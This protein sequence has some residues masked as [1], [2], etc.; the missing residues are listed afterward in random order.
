V[1]INIHSRGLDMDRLIARCRALGVTNVGY[2]CAGMPGYA[3]QG[4]PDPD[5]LRRNL[6]QLRQAGIA[7]PVAVD[8]FGNDPAVVLEPAGHRA[9]IDAACRTLSVLGEAGIPAV[10]HYIDL[11]QSQEPADDDAYW[12]G[13]ITVFGELVEAAERADVRLANHA[14]WRCIPDALRPQALADG[15]TMATY[16]QYRPEGW[17]GPYLLTSGEHIVRLL[18]AVPSSHNGACFCT[19]MYIM[20]GDLPELADALAGKIHYAQMRDLRGRWPASE[21]VFPGTGELDFAAILTDLRRVGYDGVFGPEH[22]GGPR[23]PGEDVEAA[24][25]RYFQ[26][27]LA[28]MP[29]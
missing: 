28:S 1:E 3:E 24:A 15:V 13:L 12:R 17:R 6:D 10:L 26:D 18:E 22:L 11:A 14:I 29:R 9:E 27:V 20:G 7:V 2:A 5:Q 21:E 8:W 4:W 19:G 25:V 23:T 16:R